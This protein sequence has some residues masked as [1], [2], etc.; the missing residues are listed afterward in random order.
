M[1]PDVRWRL[2]PTVIGYSTCFGA[3]P[4]IW[5]VA[6]DSTGAYRKGIAL[7]HIERRSREVLAT[8]KELADKF[9][10]LER[11]VATDP[12]NMDGAFLS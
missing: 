7:P 2:R 10:E 9:T 3:T 4:L 12:Q 8:H 11:K 1:P 6:P 5:G